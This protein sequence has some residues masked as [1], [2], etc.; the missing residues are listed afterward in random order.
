VGVHE[1][2]RATRSRGSSSGGDSDSEP[3]K[4]VAEEVR[5]SRRYGRR[6]AVVRVLATDC[7]ERRTNGKSPH[8]E[9]QRLVAFFERRI[10]CS[11]RL[12][13]SSTGIL[14]VVLPEADRT[15]ASCLVARIEDGLRVLPA[16]T[17]LSIA[18][19]PDDAMTVAALFGAVDADA[20][21]MAAELADL[22][23]DLRYGISAAARAA[24]VQGRDG[25]A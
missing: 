17:S 13:W 8:R 10:R 19:F 4:V 14:F 21:M 24:S 23:A 15:A 2:R 12:C 3:T 5:R 9:W 25:T 20:R 22:D 11:D 1:L 18:I 16:V 7:T 6:F